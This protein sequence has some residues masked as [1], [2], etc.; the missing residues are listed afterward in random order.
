MALLQLI[1]YRLRLIALAMRLKPIAGADDDPP[2]DDPPK[3]DPP[4]A[5]P[6]K[7][8]PPDDPVK[9]EDDWKEKARK[10]ERDAKKARKEADEAK[11]KLRDREAEGQ[12]DQEKA[13]AKAREEARAEAL[14]EAEKDRRSDRLEVAVT[15]LAMKGIKVGDGDDAKTLRFADAEDALLRVE[16][17][18]SRG[19]LDADEIYDSEGKVNTDALTTAL[20]DI[21]RANSHL[22][23]DGAKAPAGDPDSRKGDPASDDLE[24]MSVEEHL[25]SIQE[26]K[27]K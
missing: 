19:D 5:D 15:R 20:A 21:L 16:R 17:G 10:H 22:S 11:Q 26:T 9:P 27:S 2:K 18:I 24:G 23:A 12:S 4:K 14:T 1:R 6:P 25:K 13:I 7:D 3:D 8:D